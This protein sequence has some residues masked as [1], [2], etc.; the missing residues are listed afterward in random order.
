MQVR[1]LIHRCSRACVAHQLTPRIITADDGRRLTICRTSQKRRAITVGVRAFLVEVWPA[2]LE[3]DI[4]AFGA[5]GVQFRHGAH[6]GRRR[7]DL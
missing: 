4:A 5:V 6:D 7:R 2:E 1:P 3:A